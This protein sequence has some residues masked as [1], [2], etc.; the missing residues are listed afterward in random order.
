MSGE[1]CPNA[2]TRLHEGLLLAALLCCPAIMLTIITI[3]TIITLIPIIITIIMAI[4][5]TIITTI[6]IITILRMLALLSFHVAKRRKGFC[7]TAAGPQQRWHSR[8]RRL[9]S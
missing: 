4:I 8:S 3:I 5:I 9:H 2:A 1:C 7:W 6:I